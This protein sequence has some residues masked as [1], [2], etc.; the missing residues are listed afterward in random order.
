VSSLNAQYTKL[1]FE[2][3]SYFS[4][5]IWQKITQIKENRMQQAFFLNLLTSLIIGLTF[6]GHCSDAPRYYQTGD[7]LKTALLAATTGD[8][9]AINPLEGNPLAGK[10]LFIN[11]FASW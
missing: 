2:K 4:I 5:F 3:P 6:P 10:I 1:I 7:T 11:F 8:T 9:F